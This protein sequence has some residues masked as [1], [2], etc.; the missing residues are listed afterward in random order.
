MADQAR[1]AMNNDF[2]FFK[3]FRLRHKHNHAVTEVAYRLFVVENYGAIAG[4]R[5]KIH[6]VAPHT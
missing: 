4:G 2:G 6:N 3:N 1:Y 5:E